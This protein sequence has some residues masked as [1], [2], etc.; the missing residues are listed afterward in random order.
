MA[1][2]SYFEAAAPSTPTSLKRKSITYKTHKK[3]KETAKTDYIQE[4]QLLSHRHSVVF[5][6]IAV[7]VVVVVVGQARDGW[8]CDLWR[9]G[10]GQTM[11]KMA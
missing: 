4:R 11:V 1:F 9:S 10:G 6:N 8:S 5:V 3:A 2:S 7:V